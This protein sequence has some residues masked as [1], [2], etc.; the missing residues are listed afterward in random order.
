VY[1]ASQDDARLVGVEGTGQ[2]RVTPRL[3]TDV[4]VSYVRGSVAD[5]DDP[6]P[7]I[8]PLRVRA[9]ARHDT[10]RWF[11]G[12]TAEWSARQ[13]R[14]PALPATG[15]ASCT[16]ST[17]AGEAEL[18]PAELC[19]TPSA[20]LVGATVGTRWLW[21]GSVHSLTLAVENALDVDWRDPL[22]RAKQVAPQ[23]GRNL[24]LLYRVAR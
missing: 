15:A 8:P 1:R 10:P 3:I 17:F 4:T 5:T 14:L 19:P 2:W 16:L 11:A 18:L 24:K 9:G 6:L 7:A 20:F 22:W 12:A 21:G 23:P 13:Q